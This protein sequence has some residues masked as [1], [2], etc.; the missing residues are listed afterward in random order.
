MTIMNK[1]LKKEFAK[2]S[3]YY[4]I[5]SIYV[6]MKAF[7][8]DDHGLLT[9]VYLLSNFSCI[10]SLSFTSSLPSDFTLNNI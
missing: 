8:T 7:N 3:R 10:P 5:F 6:V 9:I 1:N 2:G 4:A